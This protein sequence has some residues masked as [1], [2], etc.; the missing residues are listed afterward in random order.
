M[1]ENQIIK[2]TITVNGREI[3]WDYGVCPCLTCELYLKKSD[4]IE[5][6]EKYRC[7]Y[8]RQK[9]KDIAQDIFFMMHNFHCS[10]CDVWFPK[11]DYRNHPYCP[12]CRNDFR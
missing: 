6:C 11:E 8:Q 7:T 3:S 5:N 10:T 2:N 4:T 12:N 1:S 9:A